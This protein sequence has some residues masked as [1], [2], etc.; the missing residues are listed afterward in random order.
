MLHA[1][2]RAVLGPVAGE[3][4]VLG[5]GA[6]PHRARLRR[7]ADVRRCDQEAGRRRD[8]QPAVRDQ[9]DQAGQHGHHGGGDPGAAPRHPDPVEHPPA[10]PRHAQRDEHGDGHPRAQGHPGDERRARSSQATGR[11]TGPP[12]RRTPVRHGGKATAGGQPIQAPARMTRTTSRRSPGARRD[13]SAVARQQRRQ[14][15]AHRR[16]SGV[17]GAGRRHSGRRP[18]PIRRCGLPGACRGVGPAVPGDA[19]ASGDGGVDC[20]PDSPRPAMHAGRGLPPRPPTAPRGPLHGASREGGLPQD[21]ASD[22]SGARR[23][24]PSATAT[25]SAWSKRP[26]SQ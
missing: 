4:R 23:T 8:R 18:R 9:D 19:A 13:S 5:D 24:S 6:D 10:D 22:P 7:P 17:A 15:A 3:V 2:P 11:V 25:S 16:G 12:P 21:A 20:R 14:V 26:S 1:S